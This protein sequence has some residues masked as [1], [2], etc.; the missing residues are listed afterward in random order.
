[1]KKQI[2]MLLVTMLSA[3]TFAQTT[4]HINVK[5]KV[6]IQGYDPVAYFESNKAIEGNK[7]ITADYNGATYQFSSENNK[8]LFLK[9]PTQ[10]EPQFGGFCA[11]G[12]SEG[13]ESPIQPEAFTI[14]DNKLY[15]NYNLK[16]REL[17]SK[18]QTTRIEKAN[19]NWKKIVSE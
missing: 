5:G 8:S 15:L 13:H 18:D 6:A 19:G 7:E 11:Y 4:K 2:L 9:N 17:W 14:V 16:V 12:V 10:Y 1:M 3:T